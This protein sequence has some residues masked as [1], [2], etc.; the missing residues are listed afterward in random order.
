MG[1]HTVCGSISNSIT[2]DLQ[3]ALQIKK[4]MPPH[5]SQITTTGFL[6]IKEKKM[7]KLIV[8]LLR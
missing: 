7:L 6:A 8:K 2:V 4:K 1:G 5:F 3:P